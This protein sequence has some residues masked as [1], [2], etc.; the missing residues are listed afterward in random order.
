MLLDGGAHPVDLGVAGDGGVVDVDHDHLVVPGEGISYK[1]L[2]GCKGQLLSL[3]GRI[4]ANPVRVKNPES[5]ESTSN[6]E[7]IVVEHSKCKRS[8][9]KIIQGDFF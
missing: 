2:I 7:E 1:S 8:N 5:L 3:V 6:L 9:K 4:L